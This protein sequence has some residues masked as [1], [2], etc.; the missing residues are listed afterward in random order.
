VWDIRIEC[1]YGLADLGTLGADAGSELGGATRI[2]QAVY[3]LDRVELA[4]ELVLR[5]DH[6]AP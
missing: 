3:V 6:H 1:H 2:E 4:L 5:D